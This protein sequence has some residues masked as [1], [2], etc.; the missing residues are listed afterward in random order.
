[1]TDEYFVKQNGRYKSIGHSRPDTMREGVYFHQNQPNGSK[2]TCLSYWIGKDPKQPIDV[3]RLVHLMAQEGKLIKYLA[4]IQF[5]DSPEYQ[6]LRV[7]SRS[8]SAPPRIFNISMQD[9][10]VAILRYLF[11][12]NDTSL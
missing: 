3:N 10:S 9:L 12:Q 2:T 8:V 4:A 5:P 11:E 6:K 1:M 7:D